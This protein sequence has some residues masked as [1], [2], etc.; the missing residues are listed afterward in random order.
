MYNNACYKECPEDTYIDKQHKKCFSKPKGEITFEFLEEAILALPKREFLKGVNSTIYI[1]EATTKESDFAKEV[2]I[3]NN[4]TYL[5][6]QECISVLKQVW[7]IEESENLIIAR[8]EIERVNVITNKVGYKIFR[9]LGGKLDLS[10]CSDL[11]VKVNYL[12]KDTDLINL[13]LAKSMKEKE[14]DIYNGEDSFFNDFCLNFTSAN[15]TDVTLKDRR[16]DYFQNISYCE[17][18][19]TYLGIDLE[20]FR[21]ECGCPIKDENLRSENDTTGSE[22]EEE[23][24]NENPPDFTDEITSSNYEVIVCY[25]Q[26][27]DFKKLKVNY[28]NYIIL[29]M[30]FALVVIFIHYIIYGKKSI[31]KFIVINN[32]YS[33]ETQTIFSMDK[34]KF[35]KPKH[36][37]HSPPRKR[38]ESAKSVN[39]I[40]INPISIS[41]SGPVKTN[42]TKENIKKIQL[43]KSKKLLSQ[44]SSQKIP[45]KNNYTSVPLDTLGDISLA[46]TNTATNIITTKRGTA[47]FLIGGTVRKKSPPKKLSLLDYNEMPYETALLID[48]RTFWVMY[49]ELV[50]SKQILLCLTLDQK[51]LLK[52][53]KF[54][55]FVVGTGMDFFFNALFYS[56]DYITRDY[57]LEGEMEFLLELPKSILSYVATALF[58][59]FLEY[60]TSSKFLLMLINSR[61]KEKVFSQCNS[62]IRILRCK[63]KVY[64]SIGSLLMIFFWY[65][66]SAFCAVFQ[67]SQ[68]KW[69]ESTFISFGISMVAPFFTCLLVAVIRMLGLKW[70][71]KAWFKISNFILLLS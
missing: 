64:M 62:F 42:E 67:N 38:N 30:I 4:R 45:I 25:N 58:L 51:V 14:I 16:E 26:V 53:I 17:K 71:S 40:S 13:K 36:N 1:Y 41:I 19:C 33:S 55:V 44:V 39:P 7:N 27:F 66:V 11:N 8:I 49:R 3:Q 10:V 37:T 57:H 28:G 29:V 68:I 32:I 24:E 60:L 63:I 56:D 59:Y 43:S 54:S 23:E 48:H 9:P 2:S 47:D 15:K 20:K 70:R 69:I 52:Q 46:N 22:E 35:K 31:M 50:I 6:F 5:E 65:Y 34:K 61:I 18:G 12:I 21:V